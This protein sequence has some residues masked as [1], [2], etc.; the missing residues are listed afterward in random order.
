VWLRPD[1][2]VPGEVWAGLEWREEALAGDRWTASLAAE[3]ACL[4]LRTADPAFTLATVGVHPDHRR[5]GA[6]HAVLRPA[7]DEADRLGVPAVLETS[8]E[9]NLLFYAALGFVLT[10]KV[11]VAPDGP[12]VWAM[13]R[14]PA[15]GV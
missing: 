6:G 5:T 15:G 10:G 4:P 1:R 8:A 11:Q 9:E 13:R 12:P 14:P 2:V 3:A 7:L